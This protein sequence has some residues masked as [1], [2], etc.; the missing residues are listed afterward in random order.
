M[1]SSDPKALHESLDL[2]LAQYLLAHPKAL[3][4]GIRVMDL[5]LWNAPRIDPGTAELFGLSDGGSLSQ[6]LVL[7]RRFAKRWREGDKDPRGNA[8]D[9]D[10]LAELCDA[11]EALPPELP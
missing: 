7:A 3:P 6:V 5:L 2:L 9:L 1:S 4:S 11:I 10:L 8:L